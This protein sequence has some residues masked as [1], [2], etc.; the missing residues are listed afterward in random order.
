[1]GPCDCSERGSSRVLFLHPR[2]WKCG[3]FRLAV[4]RKARPELSP[5]RVVGDLDFSEVTHH[6]RSLPCS[7]SMWL[8]FIAP[9]SGKNNTEKKKQSKNGSSPRGLSGKAK[10][11]AEICLAP[12]NSFEI[13]PCKALWELL[14]PVVTQGRQQ[15][16]KLA[17]SLMPKLDPVTVYTI[18]EST[19]DERAPQRLRD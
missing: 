3:H 8:A 16:G 11:S 4:C 2:G 19:F 13:Q 17:R 18:L 12:S 15:D 7:S 10:I 14:R 9:P 1:M 6:L 5:S